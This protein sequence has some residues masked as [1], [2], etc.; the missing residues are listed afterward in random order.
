MINAGSFSDTDVLTKWL[1]AISK[2]GVQSDQVDAF[3]Q[4]LRQVRTLSEQHKQVV[5]DF[6]S[7]NSKDFGDLVVKEFNV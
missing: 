2:L 6:V 1:N 3:V 7:R 4:K 5:A